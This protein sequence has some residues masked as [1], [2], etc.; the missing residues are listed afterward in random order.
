MSFTIRID[1]EPIGALIDQR[2]TSFDRPN[3]TFTIASIFWNRKNI[4][5]I[6]V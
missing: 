6:L 4:S 2:L 3:I 1:S 5:E